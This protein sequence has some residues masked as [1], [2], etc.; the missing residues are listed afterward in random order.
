MR[1]NVVMTTTEALRETKVQAI[2]RGQACKQRKARE[3][4]SVT[5]IPRHQEKTEY[6]GARDIGFKEVTRDCSENLHEDGIFSH[7]MT[8]TIA[9]Y[10]AELGGRG[11]E[12]EMPKD[13][14]A[15]GAEGSSLS[16]D[17]SSSVKRSIVK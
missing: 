11:E 10:R 2:T 5:D 13:P 3:A 12:E 16:S 14:E 6:E 9:L 8:Q 15:A 17:A 1:V 7:A 4:Q